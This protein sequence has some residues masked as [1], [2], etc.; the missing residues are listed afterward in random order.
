MITMLYTY[1]NPLFYR[2]P[3]L[4]LPFV[5]FP[6]DRIDYAN[7]RVAL[8][9]IS[10]LY[11]SPSP[12]LIAATLFVRRTGLF[13][14][15]RYPITWNT[16]GAPGRSAL[17][18]V[19]SPDVESRYPVALISACPMPHAQRGLVFNTCSRS[20]YGLCRFRAEKPQPNVVATSKFDTNS[21]TGT[22]PT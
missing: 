12:A 16:M 18:V 21:R 4:F 15:A 5:V 13:S 19:F 3:H 11:C 6:K 14:E 17:S 10:T 9:V 7:L 22:I 2:Y 8:K 1:F 20:K